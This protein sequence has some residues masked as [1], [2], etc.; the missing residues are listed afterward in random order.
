MKAKK[1]KK[2]WVRFRH[3]F[4]RN[5]LSLFLGPYCRI[6]YGIKIEKFKPQKNKQYLIL[7]NHQTAFDQFF[8]GL[9]FKGKIYYVASEDIF[10]KGFV[11]KLIKFLVEPI[12][13]KKQASDIRAIL[14]C[15][16]VAKEGGTIAIAPEG[17]RTFS[18]R[19]EYINPAIVPLAKKLG[20]PIALLRIEGGFGVH[21]RWA[22]KVRKGKM[23]SY[24]SEIIEPEQYAVM[25]N[26]ELYNRI[27][28]GLFVDENRVDGFYK[29][30]NKAEYIERAIYVCPKCGLSSFESHGDVF[31]CKKCDLTVKYEETKKLTAIKG[32]CPFEFLG[33]WYTYQNSFINSI[34][35]TEYTDEPIYVDSASFYEEIPYKNKKLLIDNAKISLYGDKITVHG[36]G[37]KYVFPFSEVN[38]VTILGKNKVDVYY[39]KRVFQIKGGK[40]FNAVKYINIFFRSN[41][42]LKGGENSQDEQYKFLGL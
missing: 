11:S 33:D 24:V 13:I 27:K 10:S 14:D 31:K 5:I 20:L 4:F 36:C 1:R 12:P 18:G 29:S 34:N 28:D 41:N 23:R 22:D 26:E 8:V 38:F 2:K 3:L 9:G 15:M 19:T 40:E 16:R 17:N 25:S 37:E 7:Y 32:E 6:K 42:I 30:K 35:T 39:E 21:P